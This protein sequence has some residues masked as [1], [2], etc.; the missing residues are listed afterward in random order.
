MSSIGTVFR[1]NL[2]RLI[3]VRAL[4]RS[5]GHLMALPGARHPTGFALRKSDDQARR[6]DLI[7]NVDK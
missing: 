2:R 6:C 4:R 3:G 1:E 7:C 5:P